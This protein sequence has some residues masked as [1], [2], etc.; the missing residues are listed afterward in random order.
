MQTLVVNFLAAL[1]NNPRHT[2]VLGLLLAA[3]IFLAVRQRSGGAA[4]AGASN[5]DPGSAAETPGVIVPPD[6][7]RSADLVAKWRQQPPAHL[8]RN[9][10]VS[11]LTQPPADAVAARTPLPGSEQDGLFW[12]QLE[13]AL[14]FRADREQYRHSLGEAALRDLAD[15]SVK[16]IVVG[17]DSRAL[18]GER[19]VRVG[20]VIARGERGPFT[21]A[22]IES[23]RVILAR[24]GHRLEMTLGRP[25]AVLGGPAR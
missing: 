19:L 5:N 3:L 21:V 7:G 18:I 9:L 20:D 1:R 23:K 11:E 14:A 25:G 12:R 4:I 2:A 6:I 17:P 22:A 10:F 15:L 13:Q 8:S 16:T 24:D